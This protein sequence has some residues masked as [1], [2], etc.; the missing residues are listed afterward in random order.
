MLAV[1]QVVAIN[2][3]VGVVVDTVPTDQLGTKDLL[4]AAGIPAQLTL[5]VEIQTVGHA[6]TVIVLTIITLDFAAIGTIPQRKGLSQEQERL[7]RRRV[8]ASIGDL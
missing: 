2:I 7:L 5:T 3:S 1:L 4:V 8:N 6:I